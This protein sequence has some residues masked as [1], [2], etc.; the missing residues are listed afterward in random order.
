MTYMR[1]QS[2]LI[3][4]VDVLLLATLIGGGAFVGATPRVYLTM[5]GVWCVLAAVLYAVQSRHARQRLRVTRGHV[6]RRCNYE[7]SDCDETHCP[8]CKRPREHDESRP[9]M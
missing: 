2:W 6:C 9:L 1:R 7:L 4:L 3:I 5:G 8:Q